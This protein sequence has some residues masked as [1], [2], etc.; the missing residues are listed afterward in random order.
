MC[1]AESRQRPDSVGHLLRPER[2]DGATLQRVVHDRPHRPLVEVPQRAEGPAEVGQALWLEAGQYHTV[3]RQ[4]GKQSPKTKTEN[5]EENNLLQTF[6]DQ[7]FQCF[8]L[9]QNFEFLNFK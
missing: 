3:A 9:N 6:S 2:L 8:K 1:N 4:C 7:H 5:S